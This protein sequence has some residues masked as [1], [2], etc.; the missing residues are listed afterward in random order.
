M[1]TL[2]ALGVLSALAATS[3]GLIRKGTE[4]NL[5]QLT[6]A[7]DAVVVGKCKSKKVN[8]VDRHFETVYE[9]EVK[10]PLKGKQYRTGSTF[11]MT[12]PGGSLES[13]PL[14]QYVEGTAQMFPEEEVVLFLDTQPL[15]LDKSVTDRLSPK[16]TLLNSPRVVGMYEG[17]FTVITDEKDGAMKITRLN[18]EKFG[19]LPS[20]NQMRT[21]LRALAKGDIA[22]TTA[23]LVDIGGGVRATE[24]V[25]QLV[26][27]AAAAQTPKPAKGAD[28]VKR[29]VQDRGGLPVQDFDEFKAQIRSFAK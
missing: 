14:T 20:D 7:S 19:F 25:R 12:V 28:T 21:I 24:D 15:R 4:K 16:S 3:W 11:L 29:A 26:D 2:L 22:S 23:P 18:M 13:P 6:K 9:I 10:E 1:G 8:V 27:R 17:K 5:E